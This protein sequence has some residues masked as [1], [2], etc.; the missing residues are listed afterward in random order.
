MNDD[1]LFVPAGPFSVK[2]MCRECGRTGY[3]CD[4][5][6]ARSWQQVCRRGHAG[7]PVCGFVTAVLKDGSPRRCTG[8][9]A[10]LRH[11]KE[12]AVP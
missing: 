1:P 4:P 2:V 3:D 5:N 6:Y 7:C 8:F 12:R 10:R 9:G 11:R